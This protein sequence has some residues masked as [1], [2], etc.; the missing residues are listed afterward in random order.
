MVVGTSNFPLSRSD[1]EMAF[2]FARIDGGLSDPKLPGRVTFRRTA[3]SPQPESG[4]ERDTSFL[5]G[6]ALSPSVLTN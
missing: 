2:Q 1:L 4:R 6:L 3:T 5:S